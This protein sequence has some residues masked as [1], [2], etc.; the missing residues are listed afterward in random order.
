MNTH[1][2]I[3]GRHRLMLLLGTLLTLGFLTTSLGSYFVSKR[4]IHD[5][6]VDRELPLT[7]DTVYS[8]IQKDLVRPVF[9]SSMMASDTFLRDWVLHGEKDVTLITK[10]LKEVKSRYGAFSSFFVADGSSTYYHAGGVLKKVR[11]DEYR[12]IWYYRVRAMSEPYEI[13][14]DL[15]MANRDT[16]TIFVNYRVLDY[17]GRYLGAT[18]VGL[19]VDAVRHLLSDYQK[20]YQ[21]SVYFVT[22]TGKVVLFGSQPLP[23][24]DIHAVSGLGAIADRILAN[25]AG[26]YQYRLDGRDH[27]LNVRYVPE[28]K[29]YLFVEKVEDDA[30]SSI[31][32]ALY[33][34]LAVC[35][36]VTLL[37]LALTGVT[38]RRYQQRLEQMATTD[39]LTG[40][41]NRQTGELL[42]EH[43]LADARRSQAPLAA[44]LI[45][46]DNFKDINDSHGHLAGDRVLTRTAELVAANLRASDLACRWGGEEFL[47]L[48]RNCAGEQALL[49]ADKLRSIVAVATI[50]VDGTAV[51]VTL[52][53]G[54]A[55]YASPQTAEQLVGRADQ[56]L[57]AAKRGGRNRAILQAS[58]T[59]SG[60]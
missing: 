43:A 29:W 3:T 47:L 22:Q 46:I 56:A 12:D 21:R 42:L 54:V 6:I 13:N 15:D 24:D 49:L 14:V 19:T 9:I 45:D 48:F 11:P 25:P 53:A 55:Q 5:A 31:R 28:L 26:S 52:S 58:A 7:S 50:D 27:L 51:H 18:G 59:E 2:R 10:Y 40:L 16:M 20:R 34:N 33:L 38:L 41:A 57:Y 36:G 39:K 35:V 4:E 17:Q 8:E 23:A 1:H 32:R 30:L 37:I 60:D 44:V